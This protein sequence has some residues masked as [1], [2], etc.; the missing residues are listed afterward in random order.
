[1]FIVGK[2]FFS[3]TLSK[4]NI[5]TIAPL[6]YSVIVTFRTKYAF[7]LFVSFFFHPIFDYDGVDFFCYAFGKRI[8]N[9]KKYFLNLDIFHFNK[10][11]FQQ[12]I[13]IITGILD[14][15]QTEL[16]IN[17]LTIKSLSLD[18]LD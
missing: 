18:Y 8:T 13:P 16:N 9:R 10:K 4:F 1:M 7:F 2:S 12:C 11:P 14:G 5:K 17:L 3:E 15:Y 6:I